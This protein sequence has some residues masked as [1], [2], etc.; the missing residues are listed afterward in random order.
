[1]T[2]T[3][4]LA[5]LLRNWLR[6]HPQI[7]MAPLVCRVSVGTQV[8]QVTVETLL[9]RVVVQVAQPMGQATQILLRTVYPGLHAT[10]VTLVVPNW[11][12]QLV[13]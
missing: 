10:Q 2:H 4:G 7:L 13:Q 3:T 8:L 9:T 5:V 1:M 11:R 6:A 12:S